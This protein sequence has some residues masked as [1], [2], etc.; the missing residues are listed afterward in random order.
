MET[1]AE[2]FASDKRLIDS[3]CDR[4]ALTPLARLLPAYVA[5]NGTTDG[6]GDLLEALKGVRT[7]CR[8]DLPETELATVGDLIRAAER[9]VYR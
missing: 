9:A 5:F 2:F 1:N 4:R 3:W 6:W 7:F 8:E